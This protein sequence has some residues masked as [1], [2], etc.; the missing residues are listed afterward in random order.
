MNFRVASVLWEFLA[1]ANAA[2]SAV[3]ERLAIGKS[4]TAATLALNAAMRTSRPK[5]GVW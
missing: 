4:A 5:A 2:D 1:T 3:S